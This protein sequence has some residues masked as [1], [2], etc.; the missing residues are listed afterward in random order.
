MGLPPHPVAVES[1]GLHGSLT[2]NY[3]TAVVLM[4]AGTGWEIY[5]GDFP[6]KQKLTI[7]DAKLGKLQIQMDSKTKGFIEHIKGLLTVDHCGMW[8][9]PQVFSSKCEV[10]IHC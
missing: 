8:D 7:V 4:V 10:E 9:D 2:K 1:E 3:N 5:Q 6:T